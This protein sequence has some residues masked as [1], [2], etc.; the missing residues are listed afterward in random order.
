M[1][2][3]KRETEIFYDFRSNFDHSYYPIGDNKALFLDRDGVIIK[4]VNYI[5]N[6][7]DVELEA[8]VIEL[9]KKAYENKLPVFIITNQSGISRGFYKWDD[10]HKVNEKIIQLI[11]QPNPIYSIYANSH[12]ESILI[13]GGNQIQI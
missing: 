6:P 5:S 9:L 2:R 3:E 1:I 4:D 8:G 11:G 13:I 10:F 12:I 7:E